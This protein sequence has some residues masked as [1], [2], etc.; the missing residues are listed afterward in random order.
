MPPVG[1][2]IARAIRADHERQA[3]ALR[4]DP[5]DYEARQA[6]E[7]WPARR[8]SLGGLTMGLRTVLAVVRRLRQARAVN[9]TTLAAAEPASTSESS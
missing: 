1:D 6:A 8:S 7:G 9:E 5:V 4:P 3:A 2:L